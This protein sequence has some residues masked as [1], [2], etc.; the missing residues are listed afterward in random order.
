M[1]F[2][3]SLSS[4]LSAGDPENQW[5]F[6]ISHAAEEKEEI[7]KPLADAL[8]ASGL[9]VW[10]VDYAL[11][12]G[13]NLRESI[14]YGLARAKSGIVILSGHFFE[15]KWTPEDLNDLATRERSGEKAILPVWHKVGFQEVLRYSP[16]LADR[17]AI[18]TDRGLEYVVQR[19]VQAAK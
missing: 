2:V 17:V 6:F 11:K 4:A 13:D 3:K 5:D 14:D 16:V 9:K 8:N 1:T 15:K 10:Y 12:L 7:A 19:I 18:S